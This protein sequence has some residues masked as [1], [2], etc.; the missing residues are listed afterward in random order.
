MISQEIICSQPFINYAIENRSNGNFRTNFGFSHRS[1]HSTRRKPRNKICVGT[2]VD[3]II[4][5]WKIHWITYNPNRLNSRFIWFWAL[6]RAHSFQCARKSTRQ[7]DWKIP[8]NVINYSQ[9]RHDIIGRV[10]IWLSLQCGNHRV[11]I[12][13]EHIPTTIL[14][15]ILGAK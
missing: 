5:T 1:N 2:S 12:T 15:S 9:T 8:I 14:R 7:R 6:H 13:S 3:S 10:K 4:A 11:P